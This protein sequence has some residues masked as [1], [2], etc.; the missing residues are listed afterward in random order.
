MKNI[1]SI[2]FDKPVGYVE[3]LQM[4]QRAFN[5]VKEKQIDGILLLLQHEPVFTFG[6]GGGYE[7]LLVPKEKLGKLGIDICETRRGGNVTYHGPGQLVVYP[8]LNLNKFKK[9][10]HWYL[11]QLEE[12]VIRTLETYGI[13]AGRK[14]EYPGV[15]VG[16]KK[17]TAIGVHAKKWITLH[18]FAF[19]IFVNKD[20]FGLINP[21]GITEFGIA[22]IDDYLEVVDYDKVLSKVKEKFKEVF[23]M[24]LIECEYDLLRSDNDEI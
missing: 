20:H 14:P 18:G 16:N 21:C 4:Q 7:N 17:I 3:G 15:W 22:S 5:L 12:V 11:R 13:T 1:Y 19:N 10:A 8:I 6:S 9:D 24:N 23:D 2:T